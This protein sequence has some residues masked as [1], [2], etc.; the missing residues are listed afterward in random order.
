MNPTLGSLALLAGIAVVL[1][2]IL[3]LLVPLLLSVMRAVESAL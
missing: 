3:T 2:G 1:V